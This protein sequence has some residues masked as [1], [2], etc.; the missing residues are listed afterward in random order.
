MRREE[1]AREGHRDVVAGAGTVRVHAEPEHLE[2][3]RCGL[4]K[5]DPGEDAARARAEVEVLYVEEVLGEDV[6]GVELRAARRGRRREA[7]WVQR[8]AR[9]A[10][11]WIGQGDADGRGF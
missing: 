11:V 9:F 4:E 8:H 3:G 5:A 1:V 7:P 6:D 2:E 10:G